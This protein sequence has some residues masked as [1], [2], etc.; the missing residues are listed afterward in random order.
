MYGFVQ[1]DFNVDGTCVSSMVWFTSKKSRHKSVWRAKRRKDANFERL[2]NLNISQ[3]QK[4]P[5][6]VW[7]SQ[8]WKRQDLAFIIFIFFL[9]ICFNFILNLSPKLKL[10][11]CL[12]TKQYSWMEVLHLI[13]YFEEKKIK[14][15]RK[16]L[17]NSSLY[18]SLYGSLFQFIS[19]SMMEWYGP[20]ES[21]D[22]CYYSCQRFWHKNEADV[23]LSIVLTQ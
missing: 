23:S 22:R 4:S 19:F 15:K 3:R 9:C 20:N 21:I 18:R 12:L 13:W 1:L 2:R 10:F 8:E 16:E 5:E 17:K 6:M 7:N 11:T 14:E